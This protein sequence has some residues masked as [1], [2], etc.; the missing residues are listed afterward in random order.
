MAIKILNA[1]GAATLHLKH[2]DKLL[3]NTKLHRITNAWRWILI[4]FGKAETQT[5]TPLTSMNQR[6]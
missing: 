2:D 3:T 6:Q 5:L 4:D 1:D